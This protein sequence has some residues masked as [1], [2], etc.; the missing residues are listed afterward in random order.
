M[1]NDMDGFQLGKWAYPKLARDGI[2]EGKSHKD[3]D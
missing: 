2:C 3:D 1:N